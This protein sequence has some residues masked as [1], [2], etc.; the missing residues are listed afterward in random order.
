MEQKVVKPL[1][2]M[3][4]L[5]VVQ[6]GVGQYPS[7]VVLRYPPTEDLWVQSDPNLPLTRRPAFD[8]LV[9]DVENIKRQL[10]GVNLKE[11]LVNIEQRL[12]VVESKLP[13]GK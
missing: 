8:M 7:V 4:C 5:Q 6:R 3:G 11:A 12:R 2:T 10:G 1:E 13:K 9:S